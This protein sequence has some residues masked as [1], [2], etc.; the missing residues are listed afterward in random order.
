[1]FS[2]VGGGGLASVLGVQ[3][4]SFF[5]KENWICAITRHHA[6]PNINILL[7]RNL[8]FESDFR[9]WSHPL[10]I[11]LHCLRAKSNKRRRDQFECDVTFC[12]N[13]VHSHARYRS[14][15][16]VCLRFQVVQIEQVDC[17]MSTKNVNYYKWKTFRDIFG[18]LRT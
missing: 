15:S 11:P 4:L 10:V 3:S 16:I 18:Q 7:T 13:F 5:T 12:L 8:P 1:M 9:Q 2:D 6:G 17:K 14:C